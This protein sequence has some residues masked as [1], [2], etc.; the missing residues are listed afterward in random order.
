MQHWESLGAVGSPVLPKVCAGLGGGGQLT[1][2]SRV[3]A[4]GLV[5]S[6]IFHGPHQSQGDEIHGLQEGQ[7]EQKQQQPRGVLD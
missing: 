6:C 2:R 7:R 4:L 1:Q 5:A 3:S